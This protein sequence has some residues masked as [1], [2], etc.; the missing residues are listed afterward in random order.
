[1]PLIGELDPYSPRQSSATGSTPQWPGADEHDEP[2][3]FPVA[4]VWLQS[5]LCLTRTQA[6][7]LL[8]ELLVP[9]LATVRLPQLGRAEALPEVPLAVYRSRLE[10]TRARMQELGLETLVVYGDREHAANLAFLTG[11][12]PRFEEAVLLVAAEGL[13]KLLVGNECLGYLPDAALGLEV[14]RFQEFSLLGQ[15]RGDSRPLRQILAE[16]GIRPGMQVGCVGW[17]Y[18]DGALVPGGELALEIPAYLVDLLRDLCGDRERVTSATAIFMH[19]QTGLRVHSEP[20]QIAQFEF[21]SGVT[22]AGVTALLTHLQ[23]GVREQDLE[24]HLDASGLTLSCHRMISFGE[25]ARRGLAS[26]G[27][28]MARIGDAYTTAFGVTGALTCRAGVIARGPEDLP[29]ALQEFYP[30]FAANYFAVTAAWY[31]ALAVGTPAVEVFRAAEAARDPELFDFALNP[32]HYLHLDEWVHSPFAPGSAVVLDSGMVL[33]MD[34]IPVS[35]GPFAYTNAEDGVVLAD[36]ALQREL[37]ARFPDCWRRLVARRDWM[38]SGLG[39]SLDDTVFPLADTTG[40]FA[41]YA[42]ALDRAYVHV[43]SERAV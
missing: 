41:P 37:E 3:S 39:I 11:F 15:P 43:P 9:Q 1:M 25:K 12:D 26:A 20:E 18:F 2:T 7:G 38:R 22:S 5:V 36:A 28:S 4:S 27:P 19:P 40:W 33:Q 14:E 30:R 16:F 6:A 21:A 10:T 29:A 8:E 23:A 13:Q 42:L 17:K 32:G 24:K 34:I 35:R 31:E